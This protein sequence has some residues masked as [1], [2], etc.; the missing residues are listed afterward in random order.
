MQT[1]CTY[2]DVY[3]HKHHTHIYINTCQIIPVGVHSIIIFCWFN[4]YHPRTPLLKPHTHSHSHTRSRM[5]TY[6]ADKEHP[7]PMQSEK[8]IC[9]RNH[10]PHTRIYIYR[11]ALHHTHINCKDKAEKK[12]ER[13]RKMAKVMSQTGKIVGICIAIMVINVIIK[14]THQP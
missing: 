9:K 12:S 8:K 1:Y 5:Y 7:Y 14:I 13:D 10:W 6:I 2:I 11:Q 3:K 4:F